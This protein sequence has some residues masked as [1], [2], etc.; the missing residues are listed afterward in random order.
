M[1]KKQQKFKLGE[2]VYYVAL[3]DNMRWAPYGSTVIAV[4]YLRGEWNYVVK[5]RP[6]NL[7][8]PAQ[9]LYRDVEQAKQKALELNK[10]VKSESKN[11]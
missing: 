6:V 8:R 5:H 1:N 3:D 7:A 11:V 2:L 4:H 9:A 10:G